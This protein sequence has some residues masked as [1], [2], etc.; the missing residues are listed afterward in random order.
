LNHVTFAYGLSG[1]IFFAFAAR[2]ILYVREHRAATRDQDGDENENGEG[3]EAHW[4]AVTGMLPDCARDMQAA[5]GDVPLPGT[6]KDPPEVPSRF[7]GCIVRYPCTP[8]NPGGTGA[9]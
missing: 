3:D 5:L 6:P 8:R 4:G 1:V 2:V 7:D 9:P